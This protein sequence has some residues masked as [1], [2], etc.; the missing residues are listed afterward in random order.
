MDRRMNTSRW[1]VSQSRPLRVR[2]PIVDQHATWVA[3][4]PIQ[5]CP[6]ACSY[7]FLT[8]RGQTGVRPEQL[9]SPAETVGLL[10]ASPYY[11]PDRP[12]ALY[13]WTDVMALPSSRVHLTELLVLLAERQTPNLVVLITKCLIPDDALDAATPT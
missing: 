6:K 13:T 4:N 5:G 7:C 2:T 8:E 3:V 11:A 9:A 10:I 12:V 1:R